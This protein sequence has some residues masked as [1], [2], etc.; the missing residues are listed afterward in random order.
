MIDNVFAAKVVYSKRYDL[1]FGEIVDADKED[2][3]SVIG[4]E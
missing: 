3:E 4:E 2:E 1:G